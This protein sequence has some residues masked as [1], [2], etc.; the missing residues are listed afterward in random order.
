M[1]GNDAPPSTQPVPVTA[2]K[3]RRA[4]KPA[5]VP[6]AASFADHTRKRSKEK[7]FLR[8]PHG[9]AVEHGSPGPRVEVPPADEMSQ[10]IAIMAE[11]GPLPKG[12]RGRFLPGDSA[13][14]AGRNGGFAKKGSVAFGASLGLSSEWL[15]K[16][17]EEARKAM[18]KATSY[19]LART[20]E[21]ALLCGG[22]CGV[23]VSAMVAASARALAS[24]VYVY[25]L[26]LHEKNPQKA[27][28]LFSASEK[29]AS[30]ARQH[31]LA[32]YELAVRE[33]KARQGDRGPPDVL[34]LGRRPA[35]TQEAEASVI[36]DDSQ[37]NEGE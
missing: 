20:S 15:K 32:A 12:P 16:A 36:T 31:E 24:S 13:S 10:P 21:L 3:P 19:R 9:R 11:R 6:D 23:G 2:A 37:S 4:R 28:K 33:G 5:S 29:I 1:S 8:A 22:T 25:Q 27:A 34:G 35:L 18:R 30:G 17:P 14:T 26:A 7:S